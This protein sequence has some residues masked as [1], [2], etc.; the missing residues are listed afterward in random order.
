V[1]D[2]VSHNHRQ[3]SLGPGVVVERHGRWGALRIFNVGQI[4]PQI[5]KSEVVCDTC[6]EDIFVAEL[7]STLDA[8]RCGHRTG[9]CKWTLVSLAYDMYRF[10]FARASRRWAGYVARLKQRRIRRGELVGAANDIGTKAMICV[11]S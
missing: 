10:Q 8:V 1:H 9:F 11:D 2:H 6:V 4:D 7:T 3:Y 5:M